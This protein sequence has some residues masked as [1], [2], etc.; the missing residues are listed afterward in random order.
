M[1][2]PRR[3]P[4][5]PPQ[6]GRPKRRAR[7]AVRKPRG[8]AK[9]TSAGRDL[10]PSHAIVGIGAS[11]GGFDSFRRFFSTTRSDSG[12][13]FVL[14]QHLDPVHQSLAAEV[15]GRYTRM[16]VVQVGGEIT[17]APNHVYVIPPGKYLSIAGGTLGLTDPV[18]PDG[19][20]M[21]ID[22][23]LRTL[24]AD[25]Q[26]RA[27][28]IVLSG[29]GTD[30]TLGLKAIKAAGGMSIA[31]D[32]S[33]AQHEGMPESAIAAGAVDQVLPPERMAEAVLT[34]LRHPYATAPEGLLEVEQASDHLNDILAILRERA[35]FDFRSYKKSTLERRIHRRMGLRRIER[36]ADYVRLVRSDP[37]E[38]KALFADL[39]ISVTSFFRDREAW[40]TLQEE[41]LRP[42]VGR[43]DA[44]AELRVWV[45]GC[46]TG[47]E[48]YSLAM[49]LLEA[50]EAAKKRCSLQLFASDVDAGAL[51]LA[52]AGFYPETIAADL[53]P[54]RLQRFFLPEGH[55]Y[56]VTRE[57]REAVTFAPQNLLADPP[58]S[59]ID[60]ISCRN[61]LMY[62][63][64]EAQRR[65][66]S[67][68]H[69]ALAEGGYLFLGSADMIGDQDGPFEVVS[70]KWRIY[71]RVGPTRHDRVQFPVAPVLPPARGPHAMAVR[72]SAGRLAGAVQHLLLERYAPACVVINRKY[73][74]VYFSGRTHDYLVQPDGPPTQDLRVL[75]L[76]G[77]QV[78]LR[79][80]VREALDKGAPVTVTGGRV[81]RGKSY[82]HVRVSVEPLKGPR[83]TDGLLLVSFADELARG[84]HGR[85][86]ARREAEE[87]LVRRLEDELTTTKESLHSTI[88]E[89][90]SSNQ[91]LRVANEEVMSANEELQSTNEELQTSKE[92]L[93][94]VNEE[95]HTVN[96]QLASKVAELEETNN[97]L[98]NLLASTN[99]PT[100]FL[101]AELRVR[102][103]TAN[104]TRL[105]S[106]ISSDVGR[107]IADVTQKYVDTDL[108]RDAETVLVQPMPI[109][110]EVEAS[111][112]RRYIRQVLPYRKPNQRIEGVVVTF[113]DV[114]AEA[115]HEA[116]LY[117]EAIVDTVR[118]PLLVL[119]GELRVQ[120]AN[121]SFYQMFDV[122]V[123]EVTGRPLYELGDR[124]WDIPGLRRLL[125]DILPRGAVMTDFEV[126][127]EF[128]R[129]G[130]RTMLLNARTLRGGGDRPDLILVAIDDITER[131][132][133]QEVLR[134]SEARARAGVDTAVDGILT[135]D[136]R[137]TI[138]SFNPAA[139]RIFDYPAGEVIGQNVKILMDAPYGDQHDGHL[140]TYL[141]TGEREMIGSGREVAGRRKG[142][143]AFPM[144][145]AI[146][147]FGGATGRRF[148]GTVR[149]I[150]ARKQ[151]EEQ[152]R[153]H[154]AE[155]AHVLRIA[156]M[157]RL[158]A[159]L[160]HE[161]NQ[162]LG[163]IANGVEA[164]AAFVR[165]G[166]RKPGKLLELLE[167]AGS[168]ALRAGEIVHRLREFVQRGEPRREPADLREL[169][170][171]ATRWLVREMEQEHVTLRLHLG[172]H[173]LPILADRIQTEQVF[174]NILQNAIDA[175]RETRARRGDIEVKAARAEGMAEIV[176][177]DTGGGLAADAVD[178]LFEPYFTTK[179]QGL[180]MGLAISQSIVEAH[181]GNL[182]VAPGEAGTGA[183]VRVAFPLYPHPPTRKRT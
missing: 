145:L 132:R 116:R 170:R 84:P 106:L 137:G 56:G 99:V 32:P 69:F 60:L 54:A 142:G 95:L 166:N 130:R 94:S 45:P 65:V 86:A 179:T 71:R 48:A 138:L 7:P 159:G 76:D 92:E 26:E 9:R 98:D 72:W 136:E 67:L 171:H 114:A 55:T 120:S 10:D 173:A 30:G 172:T 49:A 128:A 158:A 123:G 174:V 8:P 180:G 109:T 181:H 96:A 73:E 119:D 58:F 18:E 175:I 46:A 134:E 31:Q 110:R 75:A 24:A 176:V 108:L 167:G 34:F 129:I 165:A 27:I 101:D 151:A 2:R 97:D 38:A 147:E 178:R 52:R 16:R 154:Q 78:R 144:D 111:D 90:Q 85:A 17:A 62:L 53:T 23:F 124:E 20:R 152:L 182:S 41:V 28:G 148:V 57:L 157:E 121:P 68:L 64:P 51:A 93:Q 33:T 139:E 112:G 15:I 87:P 113:S 12:M 63:E 115:L 122:T 163:A 59:R 153:R 156:T 82:Q 39:L 177:H 125:G 6:A 80:A 169:V 107:P 135:I 118:E 81:R 40:Q 14:I 47:E 79:T 104:A 70:K 1:K 19:V 150:T 42:L 36:I 89:V 141:T 5:H 100:L 83:D 103:F 105:F 102:R 131:R 162:P 88:E 35:K 155:L 50:T 4:R 77:L 43:K 22:L 61:V 13:A 21:P 160:A 164:C 37:L 143:R 161:L 168:E 11:A 117:A 140:V 44:H 3:G 126:E 183:I 149:D 146:S 91:E 74:I 25:R 66:V 133:A 127:R 29:T